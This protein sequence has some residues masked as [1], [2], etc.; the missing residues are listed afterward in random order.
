MN[1]LATHQSPFPSEE[2]LLTHESYSPWQ[3]LTWHSSTCRDCSLVAFASLG[4]PSNKM[5][6]F[7]GAAD[8]GSF[9][10]GEDK[11]LA[12]AEVL[13]TAAIRR[14]AKKCIVASW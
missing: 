9:G 12:I 8:T 3:T 14:L 1:A 2:Q 4:T 11:A 7:C 5:A 6:N 13:A 10:I